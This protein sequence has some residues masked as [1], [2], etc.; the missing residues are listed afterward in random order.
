MLW[1]HNQKLVR[2][3]QSLCYHSYHWLVSFALDVIYA[4]KDKYPEAINANNPKSESATKLKNHTFYQAKNAIYD[5]RQFS[6]KM[7][8]IALTEQILNKLL[9]YVITIIMAYT[10]NMNNLMCT[11][12][13]S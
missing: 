5:Y 12:Q 8:M 6:Y 7:Q 9:F 10:F 3:S 11:F 4:T 13:L 1:L 2:L